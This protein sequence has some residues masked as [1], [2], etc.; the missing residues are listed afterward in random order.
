MMARCV[1]ILVP[2]FA[3]GNCRPS[4]SRATE[5]RIV[6]PD[7]A[8]PPRYRVIVS[9]VPEAESSAGPDGS[10]SD[11]RVW[12]ITCPDGATTAQLSC[13]ATGVR[14]GEVPNSLVVTVKAPGMRFATVTFADGR[15]VVKGSG[16]AGA[17]PDSGPAHAGTNGE[18]GTVLLEP[19]DP[20][21]ANDDYCTGFGAE[22][23]AGA[24]RQMAYPSETE[25]GPA[26][27][28]K[29]YIANIQKQPQVYFQNT[30]KH[31]IHYDFAHEVLGIPFSRQEFAARTYSGVARSALAGTLVYYPS[32]AWSSSALE[33]ATAVGPITVNFFPSDDLTPAQALLAHRLL[34]ERLL[35]AHLDGG[36][37]RVV[38]LPAG[39]TQESALTAAR[40][41]FLAREVLYTDR[42]ELYGGIALQILNPGVAYGTLRVLTPEAL[43]H[44]VVS[45]TDIVVLTRL[46]SDLPLVSG[47]ITEELQ[48]P[49]AHVNVAARSRG[50]P[51]I[52]LL[53]ASRDAR[54]AP[55][56][57][58]LVR[59]EVQGGTFSLAA[60]TQTEAEQFWQSRQRDR[61]VPA[62]D[63]SERGLPDFEQVHFADSVRVGVKAANLAEL[64]Q[65]LGDRAP[66]GFAVP[67]SAYDDFMTISVVSAELCSSAERDCIAEDRPETVC[68]QAR[69]LC[70]A[71]SSA[72]ATLAQ[73]AARLVGDSTLSTDSVLREASLDGLMYLIRH[74]PVDPKFG[75]ALDARIAEVFGTAKV[76]LRSSTN[77]EDLPKFSGAGLYQ[78]VSAS[79]VGDE[80]ASLRIRE[81]WASV[82]RWKAFEERR[83]WNI[84]HLAVRMGVA[85]D[86][87]IDDEVANGVLITQNLGDPT[88]AGMY[89]NV[90][91]GEVSVTNPEDGAVAEV[92][93]IVDAPNGGVQVARQR[94]SSLSPATRLLA[95]QEIGQL[96]RASSEVQ[97]HFAPLYGESANTLALD[98]EFKFRGPERS[99][100][101]K[102]ARPYA[103]P[104]PP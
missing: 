5:I 10:P 52:A 15:P 29:F 64:R 25:L 44:T 94:F 19:L 72:S 37:A 50:T 26:Y 46:P 60:A 70:D 90:Q 49:L 30:R 23:G 59:F 40:S 55:L 76:R 9:P 79:A 48:T 31:A 93:S 3:C 87:A 33:G 56:V 34:E 103:K 4:A 104:S 20:F 2:L 85:V 96:Y 97:A 7:G 12:G 22:E 82:W 89:V 71:S 101:I 36:E 65:L 17:T 102:Q 13:A 57:G 67:F 51:N 8:P 68:A 98:L 6:G 69:A 100:L 80:P 11:A 38:Y 47:T 62:Y 78:S 75:A 32:L 54:I 24:Y 99:L 91:K 77:C 84:D 18:V 61:F 58:Q 95:D 74:Q 66:R 28:L 14:L 83:F 45:S 21:V 88:M 16:D 42:S 35:F 53:N 86:L 73:H 1:V 63:L 43:A 92:F 39:A 41:E 27:A 81:V